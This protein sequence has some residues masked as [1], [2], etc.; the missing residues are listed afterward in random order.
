MTASGPGGRLDCVLQHLC[1]ARAACVDIHRAASSENAA[2]AG[3]RQIVDIGSM[4]ASI[5]EDPGPPALPAALLA[6]WHAGRGIARGAQA[7]VDTAHDIVVTAQGGDPRGTATDDPAQQ[8]NLNW[9]HAHVHRIEDFRHFP[10]P[11]SDESDDEE[12]GTHVHGGAEEHAHEVGEL[13]AEFYREAGRSTPAADAPLEAEWA[14]IAAAVLA[15]QPR[16]EG[17]AP[18]SDASGDSRPTQPHTHTPASL[19]L[20]LA[21]ALSLAL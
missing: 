7:E 13:A 15:R 17:F 10:E 19:W 3:A 11:H 18:L 12:S 21:L 8:A 16:A 6:L 9:L 20:S 5:A 2:A 14:E 4:R 1:P